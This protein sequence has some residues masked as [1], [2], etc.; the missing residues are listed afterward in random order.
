MILLITYLAK[1]ILCSALLYA[2]YYAALRNNRFHQ[3][4]RYYLVLITVVSL[5]IPLLK[6]PLPFS[7]QQAPS[8]MMTY[9]NRIITLREAVV[10]STGPA[11]NFRIAIAVIYG[12]VILLFITRLLISIRKIKSLI[13]HGEV[14]EVPPYHFVKSETVTAPFSFFRYIFWD[15]HTPLESTAGQQILR[16]EL[17]HLE[18]KHSADKLFMEIVTAICWINPFFHLLK[19]ELALVH[20]FIADKK[21][22]GTEV[23]GYAQTILRITFQSKQFSISN[24]FFHPPLHR[25][26]TMLTQFHT[27]RF[28]YLRR[29]MVLPLS[30][31]IFS[32]LAF[33]ADKQSNTGIQP[34]TAIEKG[35]N[36]QEIFTFVEQPP[37]YK[38]GEDSLAAFLSHN[39]R[40]PREAQEKGI[41]GTIF[42]QF[43]INREGEVVTPKTV[44]KVWGSGLEE[45]ALRVVKAMPKWNPGKQNGQLVSVQF[46][47]PV[48]FTL[49]E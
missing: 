8:A 2:Y 22:A 45:E 46:N 44:G 17:V 28:S 42:I 5:I 33:V 21:A 10:P 6:I 3:W 32:S 12:L 15:Q 11:I 47:L 34:A 30:V 20:E 37:T 25:R 1:V 9:T 26:I 38:G 14:Q 24:D 40:Y 35:K 29:I 36:I 7:A 43:V 18:E 41:Y 27:P 13:R 31:L 48:R 39:I 16:H 4:N 19:R 49:Q 23:A